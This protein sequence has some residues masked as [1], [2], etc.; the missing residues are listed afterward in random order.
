M[1]ART[2]ARKLEELAARIRVCPECPLCASRT[3]AVPGDGSPSA[4]VMIIGE[5]PGKDED[6]TGHP[7]VG[8][9]GRYLDHLLE[10]TDIQRSIF[11]ITN[12]VKCRPPA[13][14]VPKALEV[15]TCTTLYLSRQIALINPELI[16][17]LGAVAA[18]KLLGVSKVDEV[19]G[20][21]FEQEGRR[22][23]VTYHPA[24]RFYREDLAERVKADFGLLKRE[25]TRLAKVTAQAQLAGAAP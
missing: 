7:F 8:S 17:L 6:K 20:R 9:A 16:V 3:I 4:R 11:F 2:A 10:G 23:L 13:N 21:I 19:R 14:R 18:K 5:A 25:L 24:V 12:L 15:D 22:Y 1:P